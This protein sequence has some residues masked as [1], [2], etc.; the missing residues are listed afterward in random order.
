[1]QNRK[2]ILPGVVGAILGVA[3]A[4]GYATVGGWMSPTA[5]GRMADER[6][7]AAVVSALTPICVAQ[8]KGDP[9]MDAKM[10]ELK[11]A[12]WYGRPDLVM[13]DGW[14]TMPGA[15]KPN[16]AVADACVDKLGI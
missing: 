3:A 13:Q 1:M 12:G 2:W 9:D 4:A 16:K 11:A 7:T 14:A 8:A 6:A 5:A 15:A 10:A